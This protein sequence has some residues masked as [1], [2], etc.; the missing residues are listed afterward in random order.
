MSQTQAMSRLTREIRQAG[1]FRRS[2][3]EAMRQATKSTL[4]ACATMRGEM[5]GD[6]RAQTQRFLADMAKDVAAHRHATAS[7]VA[8]MASAR[9]KA[10]HQ[11]HGSLERQ[12]GLIARK[13]S[14]LRAAAA[15]AVAG[16]S[17]MHR[18]M[19]KQQKA[20]LNS[21]RRKLRADSARVVGAMHADRMKARALWTGLKH[22]G[23][24]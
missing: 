23:A 4:A 11:M 15:S 2:A 10:S 22:R 7:R 13:A 9:R 12:V 6:Y 17:S 21:A 1:E 19:A 24:A 8:R 18:K 16:F 14:D 20:S 3:I 5:L